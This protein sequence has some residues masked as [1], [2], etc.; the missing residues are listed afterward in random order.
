MTALHWSIV[1]PH[2]FCHAT[3]LKKKKILPNDT[4]ASLQ[5]PEHLVCCNCRESSNLCTQY[6]NESIN[7]TKEYVDAWILL[8]ERGYKVSQ[9]FRNLKRKKEWR[10]YIKYHT[11]CGNDPP[12]L[13]S[14][15]TD[16]END[17]L[18]LISPFFETNSTDTEDDVIPLSSPCSV[19]YDFIHS[20]TESSSPRELLTAS[21]LFD[22]E[23]DCRE[24]SPC[25][26]RKPNRSRARMVT[27]YITT[28]IKVASEACAEK[29]K[30]P[31]KKV[32]VQKERFVRKFQHFLNEFTS[33]TPRAAVSFATA[34]T[35]VATTSIN[36]S[37]KVAFAAV[38]AVATITSAFSPSKQKPPLLP[39]YT[40]NASTG[41]PYILDEAVPPEEKTVRS[42]FPCLS[43]HSLPTDLNC[44]RNELELEWVVSDIVGVY[45][46]D[47]RQKINFNHRNG[48]KGCLIPCPRA[49]DYNT[50]RTVKKD[51]IHH[52]LTHMNEQNPELPAKWLMEFLSGTYPE[53]FRAVA[54]KEGL[55][56][57]DKMSPEQ[58]AA[59]WYEANLPIKGAKTI[60][61]HLYNATGFRLSGPIDK[62]RELGKMETPIL[63]GEIEIEVVDDK[64][65]VTTT[66]HN[67]WTQNLQQLIEEDIFRILKSYED[68]AQEKGNLSFGFWRNG[69]FGLDLVAGSDHGQGYSRFLVKI[70]L[71]SPSE[72]RAGMEDERSC[73]IIH[74]ARIRCKTDTDEILYNVASTIE[75]FHNAV[76]TKKLMAMRN[77][78][79]ELVKTFMV[80]KD[81]VFEESDKVWTVIPSFRLK[82]CG[83]ICYFFTAMGRHGYSS[84]RC[85]YCN[86]KHSEFKEKKKGD[87]ITLGLLKECASYLISEEHSED[88]VLEQCVIDLGVKALPMY[89]EQP[90]TYMF[91]I[92]HD[93]MGIFNKVYL[94]QLLYLDE[95]VELLPPEEIAA[96]KKH[97]ETSEILE[98]LKDEVSEASIRKKLL[99][100]RRVSI[101]K[102]LR[103]N[104]KLRANKR[105]KVR[106]L[107]SAPI[108]SNGSAVGSTTIAVM[109][110][111]IKALTKDVDTLQEQH[112]N[113]KEEEKIAKEDLDRKTKKKSA[114]SELLSKLA[115]QIKE[116]KKDRKCDQKGMK[117]RVEK[118]C[119]RIANVNPGQYHG[120]D[121]TGVHCQRMSTNVTEIMNEVRVLSFEILNKRKDEGDNP[122]CTDQE[123]T[124][125]LRLYQDIFEVMDSVFS[126]LRQIDPTED[127]MDDLE[128]M[129]K[130]LET[131]WD[132]AGLSHTVKAHMLFYHAMDQVRA[133]G[134]IADLVED[135]VEQAHQIGMMMDHMTKTMSTGFEGQQRSQIERQWL[136]TD[137]SVQAIQKK[138]REACKR[139]KRKYGR[140]DEEDDKPRYLREANEKKKKK[141]EA[142][143]KRFNQISTW[144]EG[145][146]QLPLLPK[147]RSQE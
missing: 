37:C 104:V 66:V 77:E 80:P 117:S 114:A 107:K 76:K 32:K 29:M 93:F 57:F 51:F 128:S 111:Q 118:I 113:A 22:N 67:Y 129:I 14:N 96:R 110:D 18:P 44:E 3:M 17:V 119:K 109:E 47:G 33:A 130:V 142:T 20:L 46:K 122:L 10:D 98:H 49:K 79:G 59:M 36:S 145:Y 75:A 65:K 108:E 26:K 35:S 81:E 136:S 28:P 134:G 112:R 30:T 25:Q 70:N 62:V 124:D 39:N 125:K 58:T 41:R 61:K 99:Y 60:M 147:S 102:Q 5:L 126:L 19:D 140:D 38:A 74:Y 88:N 132:M 121:F 45:V 146:P 42:Q 97:Y 1:S 52:L 43:K 13:E 131:L 133:N 9:T 34:A 72:R 11:L 139:K 92:L 73:R 27:T 7:E 123:L 12:T 138:V 78:S 86:L 48:R 40:K 71:S 137:P 127:E 24:E 69:S 106:E 115:K 54:L 85:P 55:V 141:R 15:S 83:D 63:F 21:R 8:I 143:F 90:S 4:C 64:G 50:F 116:M 82:I 105:K 91:P 87:P 120:G 84:S 31:T 6:W 135:F 95:N 23:D 94:H 100:A 53:S 16:A 89:N 2:F 56:Q 103:Q 101:G 144:V 68:E